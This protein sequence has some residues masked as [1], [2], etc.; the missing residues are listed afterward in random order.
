MKSVDCL[1][2]TPMKLQLYIKHMDE[3]YIYI[4]EASTAHPGSFAL[5][6][7]LVRMPYLDVLLE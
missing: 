2:P 4:V 6:G 7:W 3:W 5:Y 1:A